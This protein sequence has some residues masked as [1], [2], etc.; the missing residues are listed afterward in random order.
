[1]SRSAVYA[2]AT[3]WFITLASQSQA[4]A[5]I[6]GDNAPWG[7]STNEAAMDAAF[8]AGN[9]DDLRM[10]DGV[11]PFLPA[12]GHS[13]IYL[14]GSDYSAIELNDYLNTYRTEIEAFVN[15][16]GSLLL[17]SAPNEGGDI[18]FGF[19]GVTLTYPGFTEIVTAADP[20]NPIFSGIATDYTGNSFGHA[21]VGPGLTP[22]IVDSNTA[23][24][25]VLGEKT[26]GDGCVLL[27]GMTTDNFHEPQPDASTLR[28][29]I[30]SYTASGSCGAS[31]TP[32]APVPALS[33]W[34]LLMLA[35]LVG[36]IARQR[37]RYQT[38]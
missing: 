4:T 28:A 27:G 25:V 9:W 6:R 33:A 19:G 14:E 3:M 15:N 38:R 21:I 2:I 23:T 29:N 8:G 18:N 12:S 24:L 10:A 26:F 11:T 7:Q 1:M 30:L 13:F 22:L 32:A 36:F 37:Q 34:Q 5:Y 31:T 20:A 16:G 17:N 35:C